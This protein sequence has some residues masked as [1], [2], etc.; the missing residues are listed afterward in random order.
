MNKWSLITSKGLPALFAKKASKEKTHE[1]R[2]SIQRM[3]RLGQ[4]KTLNENR[5]SGCFP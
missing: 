3:Y 1:R 4:S 5:H 2:N